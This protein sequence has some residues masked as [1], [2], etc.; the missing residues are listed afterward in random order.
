MN[1]KIA[2][3]VAIDLETLGTGANAVVLSAGFV[4]FTRY[5][6][7]VG[8]YYTNFR[9]LEQ[10]EAGRKVEQ[11][12]VDWWKQQPDGV[13]AA[14]NHGSMAVRDALDGIDAF[15][16]RFQN[17]SYFIEGVWGYGSDFDNAILQSLYRSFGR[18]PPWTYKQNRCGRTLMAVLP[19]KPAPEVGTKHHALDDAKWLAESIRRCLAPQLF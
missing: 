7:I 15:F 12:T 9:Q 13:F 17:D 4:A 18:R 19:N 2:I 14:A 1:E 10:Q 5:G 3:N 8:S 16:N 6:G 11:E